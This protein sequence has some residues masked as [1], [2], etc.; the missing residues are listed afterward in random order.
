[1][2]V[3]EHLLTCHPSTLAPAV[4]SL[5]SALRQRSEGGL[6]LRFKLVGDI[7]RLRIAAPN[8]QPGRGNRLW[9]T[10]CFEV[11]LARADQAFYREFNFSPS[12]DWATYAFSDYRTPCPAPEAPLVTA[13]RLSILKTPGRFELEAELDANAL[14]AGQSPL[15]VGLTAVVE[16]DDL[17]D[18]RHSYW[19]LHHPAPR[20]DFH[21]RAGFVLRLD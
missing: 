1:M 17:T 16:S 12:G 4:Q 5:R 2:P 20:P 10:T 18:G 8:P 13:P 9:E 14:P 7:A 21:R 3:D 11:F 15:L 19:A 6:L